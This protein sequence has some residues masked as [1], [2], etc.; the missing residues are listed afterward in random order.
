M[1]I[2]NKLMLSCLKA[3]EL[4]ERASMAPLGPLHQLQLWMHLRMCDG[5]RA[6][7]SQ[8]KIIDHFMEARNTKVE[9]GD[10]KVLEDRILDQVK[11]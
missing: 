9:T 10:T 3:T 5:C 11:R 2:M 7:R 8:S 4:T 1:N 6:F